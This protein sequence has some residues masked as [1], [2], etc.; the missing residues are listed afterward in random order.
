MEK[1]SFIKAQNKKDGMFFALMVAVPTIQFF[2]FYVGVNLNSIL[3]AFKIYN[4]EGTEF[5]VNVLENFRK[6][7]SDL[8]NYPMLKNAITNSLIVAFWTILIGISLALI[9]SL[10]INRKF[11]GSQVFKVILFLPSILSAIIIVKVFT[12]FV[13]GAIPEMLEILFNVKIK[14]LMANPKTVWGTL[15]FFN[16]WISFGTPILLYVGA[17]SSISTSVLEAS[18]IDGA[19]FL[20]ES[21]FITLPLIWPTISTFVIVGVAGVLTNQFNLYSFFGDA[22]D[23]RLATMGYWLYC[24]TI[25]AGGQVSKYPY[26]AAVGLLCTLVTLP[27]VLLVRG[28]M[29]KIGPKTE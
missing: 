6:V 13:D 14:G 9:F 20:Q 28:L 15:V 12:R 3:L 25:E 11:F 17:M 8:V 5:R 29:Q 2:F 7:F 16:L 18:R 21:W 1:S 24:R 26:I 27:A 19:S 10:Y 22:A 23:Y 4:D